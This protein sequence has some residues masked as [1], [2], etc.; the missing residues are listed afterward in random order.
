MQNILTLFFIQRGYEYSQLL[1][2]VNN[3]EED[4]GGWAN[5]HTGASDRPGFKPRLHFHVTQLL[6]HRFLIN[7]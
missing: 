7:T 4:T 2:H 5:A 1:Y 3:Q 6:S